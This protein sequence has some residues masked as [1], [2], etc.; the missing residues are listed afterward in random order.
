[1]SAPSRVRVA[2]VCQVAVEVLRVANRQLLLADSYRFGHAEV[3][4]DSAGQAPA[5]KM[6]SGSKV[7]RVYI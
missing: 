7:G 1:M 5:G 2:H 4:E 6:A 3:A